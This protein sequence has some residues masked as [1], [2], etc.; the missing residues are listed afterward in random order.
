MNVIKFDFTNA[1]LNRFD[2]ADEWRSRRTSYIGGSDAG[3]IIGANKWK[4]NV[5]LWEEKVGIKKPADLS[6]NPLV[7]YGK[8]AEKHLRELFKLDFPEY[9]VGYEDNNMWLNERYPFAHASLDGWITDKDGHYGILEI[10][11]ATIN[12]KAH[13]EEWKNG[14]PQSYYA[15]I[16]HYLMVTE[17]DFAIVKAQLKYDFDGEM[18]Y[19]ATK[20]YRIDRAE[21]EDEISFLEEEER[22]FA[23]YIKDGIRPSL[24]LPEI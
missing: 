11:T 13:G 19:V 4:N 10:K 22:K 17:F 21:I 15:Q 7:T 20:H 23:Q 3:V 14:I 2:S 6:K 24:N 1:T 18:L 8:E 9:S 5:E 12:S 16:L